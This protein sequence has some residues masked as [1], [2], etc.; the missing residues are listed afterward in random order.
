MIRLSEIRLNSFGVRFVVSKPNEVIWVPLIVPKP[1]VV[2]GV[3]LVVPKPNEVFWSAVGCSK[4]EWSLLE[5]SWLF[6]NRMKSFG[7]QLVVPKRNEDF[8]VQ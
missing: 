1:N 6:Q 5:C 3:Q 8:G 2:F 4:A 7:V